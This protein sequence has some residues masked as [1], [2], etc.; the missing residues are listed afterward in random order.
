SIL[1]HRELRPASRLVE[2]GLPVA[3]ALLMFL[4]WRSAPGVRIAA[5]IGAALAIEGGAM[6]L[7]NVSPIM[8]DTSLLHLAVLAYLAA[9][10]LDEIDFRDVL[11]LIAEKRF[12]RVAMS[13]GDGLV[14]LDRHGC[15]TVWN[16]GAAAIFGYQSAEVIGEPLDRVCG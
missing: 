2:F 4:M 3:L 8:A 14:C 7:Q 12:Q 15:I 11:G 10:A 1:Q 6:A 9:I 5:L 16:P 13:L